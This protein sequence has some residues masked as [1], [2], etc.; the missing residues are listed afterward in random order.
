MEPR[1]PTPLDDFL[2]D[3]RGYL[4][5]K[6]AVESDLVDDLNRA[7]DALPPPGLRAVV[8]Q[9][10]T[11]RLPRRHGLRAAQM[12]R[13]RRALRASDRPPRLDQL[14]AP[15]L[16]RGAVLRRGALH[17]RVYSVRAALGRASSRPLRRLPGG[18]ARRLPLQPWGLP[19]RAV[20]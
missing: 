9:C 20:Q 19:L 11:P 2:F 4:I 5:L 12:R 14:R 1:Q 17:R 7:I 8:W 3:L 16:R 15:L 13:G 6:Q 18:V 10:A